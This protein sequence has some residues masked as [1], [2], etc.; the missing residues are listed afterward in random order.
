[1]HTF[2]SEYEDFVQYIDVR[3]ILREHGLSDFHVF[4][5]NQ[6]MIE[7]RRFWRL[8]KWGIYVVDDKH[9]FITSKFFKTLLE[10]YGL[11]INTFTK[12]IAY[13]KY[14]CP[15]AEIKRSYKV[16]KGK[17]T[18]GIILDIRTFLTVLN[19]ATFENTGD[20]RFLESDTED[21][22]YEEEY[23]IEDEEIAS[24]RAKLEKLLRA[25]QK[26]KEMK[27]NKG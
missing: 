2:E 5:L 3:A 4:L 26:L 20:F 21:E 13:F 17:N 1:M 15:R 23:E 27:K 11:R 24:E 14:H 8:G 19:Q 18:Y 9:V 25:F 16:I 12:L 6:A 10:K 22:E 7:I